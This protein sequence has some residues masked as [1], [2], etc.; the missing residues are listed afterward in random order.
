MISGDLV[1]DHV[2]VDPYQLREVGKRFSTRAGELG[3]ALPGF[4]ATVNNVEKA[5]GLLGP[6]DELYMEYLQLAR[7]SV[8]GLERLHD[9][10]DGVAAGLSVTADNYVDAEAATTIP[11]LGAGGG[12]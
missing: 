8:E 12:G 4:D 3:S 6:S 10:L 11:G 7:E 9:A 5:F 1:A 2:R